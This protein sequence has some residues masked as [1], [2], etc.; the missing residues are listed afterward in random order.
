MSETGNNEQSVI[1]LNGKTDATD[2]V[3]TLGENATKVC[4]GNQESKQTV[5]KTDSIHEDA[6][7]IADLLEIKNVE[8]IRSR[9]RKVRK[10][11]DRIEIVTNQL[12]EESEEDICEITDVKE[13]EDGCEI[14][15]VVRPSDK[16]SSSKNEKKE[17]S[18]RDNVM[19]KM[20][21]DIKEVLIFKHNNIN[22]SPVT[23]TNTFYLFCNVSNLLYFLGMYQIETKQSC[24]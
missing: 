18:D 16:P 9:L 21:K 20:L 17:N 12:L 13:R 11:P 22:Q 14:V 15:G 4:N 6:Q 24:C 7:T 10:N 1:Q 2:N 3:E 5:T 23:T 8:A 19:Q